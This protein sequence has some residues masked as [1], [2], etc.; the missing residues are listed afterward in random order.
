MWHLSWTT[1]NFSALLPTLLCEKDSHTHLH[2]L[3]ARISRYTLAH[4][5]QRHAIF[6]PNLVVL[7]GMYT[8]V[9]PTS[10][11]SWGIN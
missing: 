4:S 3:L 10:I 7:C 6:Y 1:R 5:G 8:Y 11:Q 2:R 9:E